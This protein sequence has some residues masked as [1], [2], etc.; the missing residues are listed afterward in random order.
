MIAVEVTNLDVLMLV[1]IFVLLV[2]LIFLSVAEMGLSR[3]SR[4]RATSLADKGTKGGKA[5]KKLVDEPER[6][7]NPLLL[8]VNVCQILQ[9]TLT[10]IV[11]G[12]MFGPAGVAVGVVL[13]VVVFFVLA[14][15]VPKTYAV[16]YPQRAALVSAR[17]VS[18][19]VAFAPL[20]WMSRGLIGLTNII[21]KGKGLEQ[22]P[23]VSESELLGIVEGAVDDDVIE[24]EERELIESIIEFGD[25]V[26]REIMVPRPD[27]ITIPHTATVSEGLDVALEHGY[28]RLPVVHD[29]E[30]DDVLGLAYA[31]DLMRAERLGGGAR[32]ISEL[33]RAVKFVPE[34]KPVNRLMREM[35]A[36]KFHL[37][38]VADEYGALAGLITLEDCLEELVGE[39]VDEHDEEDDEVLRLGDGDYLVDGGMGIDDLN[40]LLGV[41]IPDDDW[42]TVAGFLFGTLEHVP[43]EG[44]YIVREGWRFSAAAVDGRRIRQVK[45]TVETDHVAPHSLAD[46]HDHR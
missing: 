2:I 19:L 32:P 35:Q 30:D 25:T 41:S 21:V 11:A 23:F 43:A 38:L 20:R 46:E 16:L 34:N 7:V 9:A 44:E 40:D 22:G 36:E 12:N 42:D 28:S 17:P 6:W 31:K 14:E 1:A 45:I 37:A 3:M 24:E 10:S 5:L 13:N 4:P 15:A 26:A 27:I 33:L 29:D 18:A 39:I 8:T